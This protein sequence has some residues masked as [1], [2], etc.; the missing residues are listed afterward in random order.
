V[1]KYHF[2]SGLPRSGSTLLVSILNQNPKFYAEISNPLADFVSAVASA[3]THR[4]ATH[5]I[6]C[7]PDRVADTVKGMVDGYYSFTDKPVVFNT[8]RSWTRT[9]EYLAAVYPD[10][11]LICTVRDYADVLNS[12][13]YLYK[14]RGIREDSLYGERALN[15]YTRTVALDTGYVRNSYDSLKECYYGPY[16]KHLLLVEYQ[17]LVTAPHSTMK[18]VYDFI[19]EP[20]FEHDFND[21]EYSFPEYDH[22][23]NFPNLHT[24]RKKLEA[25]VNNTVLPPDLYYRFKG[26][27]FWRQRNE[28]T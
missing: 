10:F 9:P 28:H 26:M 17:D 22:A 8:D 23:T 21:V 15:V 1:N 13:E 3:Y 12:F 19:G 2:I 4:T 14:K 5:K 18:E 16:R 11:K 6:I 27:E 25:H 20:Y 24:V 7:P